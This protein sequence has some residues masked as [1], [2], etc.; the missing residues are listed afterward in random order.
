M[1][2]GLRLRSIIAWLVGQVSGYGYGRFG[3]EIGSIRDWIGSIRDRVR[4][5]SGFGIR[6]R[7]P[8]RLVNAGLAPGPYSLECGLECMARTF[9]DGIQVM[10][11]VVVLV[12][13][14]GGI[15]QTSILTQDVRCK[16]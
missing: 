1:G 11:C 6:L 9:R 3:I 10:A 13:E 2:V 16:M 15:Y 8:Q 7:S 12:S 5:R 4:S 14:L